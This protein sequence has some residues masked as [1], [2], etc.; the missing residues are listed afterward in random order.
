M[1]VNGCG[2]S[3]EAYL[4]RP[5]LGKSRAAY[6]TPRA[7]KSA[8]RLPGLRPVR[9]RAGSFCLTLY[10]ENLAKVIRFSNGRMVAAEI[11]VVPLEAALVVHREPLVTYRAATVKK[12]IPF[13][14]SQSGVAISRLAGLLRNRS[15]AI[16]DSRPAKWAFHR[17]GDLGDLSDLRALDVLRAAGAVGRWRHLQQFAESYAGRLDLDKLGRGRATQ[18]PPRFDYRLK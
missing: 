1:L 6:T 2:V 15:M 7:A 3:R 12:G 8:E 5:G 18:S 10:P 17:P 4:G 14:D 9:H 13:D 11:G 16:H